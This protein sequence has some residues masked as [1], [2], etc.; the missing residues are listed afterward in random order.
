MTI[1]A[2]ILLSRRYFALIILWKHSFFAWHEIVIA[3]N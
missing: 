2:D 3:V 1:Y